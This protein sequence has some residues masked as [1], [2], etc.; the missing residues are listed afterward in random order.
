MVGCMSDCSM[1]S[2]LFSTELANNLWNTLRIF[3]HGTGS[4]S[5]MDSSHVWSLGDIDSILIYYLY[6][7][8]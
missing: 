7:N 4:Y 5:G 8:D 1:G 6:L 2:H 3:N